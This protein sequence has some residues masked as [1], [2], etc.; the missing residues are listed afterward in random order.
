LITIFDSEEL[1]YVALVSFTTF[2]L[3]P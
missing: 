1:K 3:S 2:V